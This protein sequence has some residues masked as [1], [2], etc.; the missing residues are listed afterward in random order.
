MGIKEAKMTPTNRTIA[1]DIL[2]AAAKKDWLSTWRTL[3]RTAKT[4]VD[5]HEAPPGD[6]CE[7]ALREAIEEAEGL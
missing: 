4:F 1:D 6:N 7:K 3:L 2:E 5:L